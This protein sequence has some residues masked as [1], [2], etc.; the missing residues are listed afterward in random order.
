MKKYLLSS[1]LCNYQCYFILMF[2]LTTYVDQYAVI[3]LW[4][5]RSGLVVKWVVYVVT[6]VFMCSVIGLWDIRFVSVVKENF[7]WLKES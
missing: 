3:G 6:Q 5:I 7:C 1:V 4:Y 2:N